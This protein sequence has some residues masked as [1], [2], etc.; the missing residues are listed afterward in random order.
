[1]R[2]KIKMLFSLLLAVLLLITMMPAVMADSVVEISYFHF[3]GYPIC[4]G[5]AA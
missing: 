3:N 4:R 5:D 2:R 1:M